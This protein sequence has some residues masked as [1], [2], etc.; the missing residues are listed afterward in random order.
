MLKCDTLTGATAVLDQRGT[1]EE[2]C[3]LHISNGTENVIREFANHAGVNSL[4][5]TLHTSKCKKMSTC[6]RPNT[7]MQR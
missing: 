3:K 7:S 2:G 6:Q 4:G 5:A 1:H